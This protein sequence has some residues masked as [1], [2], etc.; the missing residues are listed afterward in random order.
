MKDWW[1]ESDEEDGKPSDRS[2]GARKKAP[3]RSAVSHCSRYVSSFSPPLSHYHNDMYLTAFNYLAVRALLLPLLRLPHRRRHRRHHHRCHR[4]RRVV[5]RRRRRREIT[6]V[7]KSVHPRTPSPNA[8]LY[9]PSQTLTCLE[10]AGHPRMEVMTRPQ[11]ILTGVNR[12]RVCGLALLL[13]RRPPR[14]P[15]T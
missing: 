2:S 5:R 8:V 14:A 15:M 7:C 9:T 11:C 4:E 1:A 10:I 6:R 12:A 3:P 13:R